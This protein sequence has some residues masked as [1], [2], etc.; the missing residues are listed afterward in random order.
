MV[1][2]TGAYT[3]TPTF[4]APSV[5]ADTILSFQLTVTDSNAG[6]SASSI[7]NVLVKKN[8]LNQ[9]PIANAGPNQIVNQGSFVRLDGTG[10]Y[11]PSGGVIVGYSWVQTAGIPITLTGAGT[12][13]PTFIAPSVTADTIL[14]FSLVVTNNN[15]ATSNNPATVYITVKHLLT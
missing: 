9:S 8:N 6:A 3:A 5:T 1:G 11:D 2:L 13:T 12:A 4:I 15:G 10:S 7:V 14:A